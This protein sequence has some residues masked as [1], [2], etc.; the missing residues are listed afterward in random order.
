M[1]PDGTYHYHVEAWDDNNNQSKSPDGTVVVK[2]VPPSIKVSTPYLI[3]SPGGGGTKDTLPITQTGSAED[4]WTAT[5]RNIEGT[6]VRTFTWQDASPPNIDWDGKTDDG[7]A[8]PDGVYSYE[9]SATDRAGTSAR[10]RSTTSSSIRGRRR[11][12]SPIDL[13]Y[14]SP[15]DGAE[16]QDDCSGSTCR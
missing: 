16:G 8:A 4:L 10:P 2:T 14:F 7:V 3:F 12:S 11:S 13:S 9:I 6:A 1:V 5:I 15:G